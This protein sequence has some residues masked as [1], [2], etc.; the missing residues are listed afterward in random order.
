MEMAFGGERNRTPRRGQGCQS[1]I[2]LG[3]A[4]AWAGRRRVDVDVDC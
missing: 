3:A 2:A 1:V 4:Y